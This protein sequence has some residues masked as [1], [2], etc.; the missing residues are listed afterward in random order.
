MIVCES[1]RL[2]IRRVLLEDAGF[3]VRQLNQPSWL[4]YIGDRAVRSVEDAERYIESRMLEQYRT[5]GYGMNVVQL[6]STGEPVG[7]CGL[8]KRDALPCPDLGFALLEDY[9]GMGYGLEAAA[10]VVGHACQV[11]GMSRLLAVTTAD[12]ERSGRILVELG[13]RLW[14]ESYRMDEGEEVRLYEGRLF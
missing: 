3:L 1:E 9:W 8:V 13:F 10:A 4:R 11:L 6:K 14:K 2:A 7:V 12:N 5:L